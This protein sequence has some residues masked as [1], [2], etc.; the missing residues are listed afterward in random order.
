MIEENPDCRILCI[1]EHWKSE[2]QLKQLGIT[3]FKLTSMFCRDEGKHGGTAV[4]VEKSASAKTR[5][6]LNNLSVS[7]V[8]ECAA[9]E[10]RISRTKIIIVVA[11]YRPPSGN[12]K[13][14]FDKLELLLQT[15][16]NEGKSIFLAGDFNIEMVQENQMRSEFVAILNTFNLYLCVLENTRITA[17]SKSCIDNILTNSD[18]IEASVIENWASDHMAQRVLFEIPNEVIDMDTQYKRFFTENAKNKF[19]CELGRQ[20]WADVYQS[21]SNNIDQQWSSFMNTFTPIFNQNFPL[22]LIQTKKQT[23]IKLTNP[24]LSACKHKLDILLSLSRL[25]DKYKTEYRQTKKEYD[26]ILKLSHINKY[27]NKIRNSDNKMKCMWSITKEITGKAK[28]KSGI[29]I[30]GRADCIASSYNNFIH[31]IVPNMQKH[32]KK[33]PF[34]HSITKNCQSMFLNPVTPDEICELASQVKNKLSS[35]LDE[36]PS[37][38]VKC[39]ALILKDI[40]SHLI[41]SSFVNGKFPTE[42]KTALIKPLYKKG[43]PQSFDSYRP[44]SLLPSFSKLFELAMA[45][46]IVDFMITN[47]IFSTSQHGFLKG[48]STQT[49]IFDFS[50]RVLNFMENGKPAMGIFLDL[51]KAYDSLDIDLLM[52]KLEAYGVRGCALGWL[53]SFLEDRKQ[54]VA[55]EKHSVY[56]KSNS[57]VN[58]IGIPQGSIL[59]PTLFLIFINDLHFTA[60]KPDQYVISFAD[61]TNLILGNTTAAKLIMDTKYLTEDILNWFTK[62]KLIINT[63]KTNVVYF[64]TK[65]SRRDSINEVEILNSTIK[66]VDNAKFLGIYINK[67]MDW[68]T[69][70]EHLLGKLSSITYGIRVVGKYLNEKSLKILYF[71][72]LE[73]IMRYGIIF[74]GRDSHVRSVFVAQKRCLRIVKRMDFRQSCRSVF[75]SS[76][77]MTVYALYI[78][79]CLMFVSKNKSLFEEQHETGYFTRAEHLTYA[80]HRLQ[81]SEKNPEYMCVKLYN[82]L[83]LSIKKINGCKRFKNEVKKLLLELEP[84]CIEDY[85]R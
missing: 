43:D 25:S 78:F 68:S 29:Q 40:L 70:I 6:K 67:N 22:K 2:S 5:K 3:N 35:G 21:D 44:I 83:P 52:L 51:S 31:S 59:G 27:E 39:S 79:E 12:V 69:H 36:I 61:D 84:Y 82:K 47:E 7:G 20:N 74:W 85:L 26:N 53:S 49:A 19:L 45:K 15:I 9:A 46:R 32:L 54:V 48:K 81:L 33:I 58:N 13:V 77:I 65:Q 42:L 60:M 76:G 62:N 66:T 57:L 71:A 14:F 56:A 55:I 73:S 10:V 34:S 17:T 75:R 50:K 28:G 37:S 18:L 4:F 16:F 30:E 38:I 1:S 8:F 72:N 41:N 64:K 11:I 23:K 80:Q 24:E 63:D